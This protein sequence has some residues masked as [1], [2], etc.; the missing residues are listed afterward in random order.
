MYILMYRRR[1]GAGTLNRPM[2]FTATIM[3]SLSTMHVVVDLARALKGFID[4]DS[5]EEALA[6]YAAI[7]DWLSIFKQAIYATNK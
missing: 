5:A 4:T 3:F 2:V 7:W 1:R 6:Y